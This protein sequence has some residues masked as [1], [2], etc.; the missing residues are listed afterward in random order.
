MGILK[1]LVLVLLQLY[2]CGN[3]S[4][5]DFQY[6]HVVLGKRN[7]KCILFHNLKMYF[8]PWLTSRNNF[9]T[10]MVLAPESTHI[11]GLQNV[12]G[13]LKDLILHTVNT[14][15]SVVGNMQSTVPTTDTGEYSVNN[16]ATRTANITILEFGLADDLEKISEISIL[17]S[18]A[19]CYETHEL[20]ARVTTTFGPIVHLAFTGRFNFNCLINKMLAQST[21]LGN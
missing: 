8:L 21:I 9:F 4:G 3:V 2:F 19:G 15:P 11:G 7:K 12:K 16:N 13:K 1:V 10:G 20:N 14:L 5:E 18:L 6:K 17:F